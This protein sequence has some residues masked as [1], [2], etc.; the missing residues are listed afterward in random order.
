[1]VMFDILRQKST[2]WGL[3]IF[4]GRRAQIRNLFWGEMFYVNKVG[5]DIRSEVPGEL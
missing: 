2:R 3:V 1:M 4:G 5:K